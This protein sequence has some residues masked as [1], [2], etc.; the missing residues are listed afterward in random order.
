MSTFV[1]IHG[2]AH[3][4][5]CW[6]KV[7]AALEKHGHTVLAPDLPSHG[8]DKT[9]ISAVTL[10]LYVDSVC[11]LLD[12][13]REP[14]ILVGHSMGGG[15]ITQAAE[16]RPERIK[17]LVYLTAALPRNGQSMFEEFQH[18]TES[19]ALANFVVAPDQS[20]ATF[21]EAGLKEAFY[22]DCS[23]EDITLA[24]LLLTPQ[25]MAPITTPVKTS[26]ARWGRVPRVYIECLRDRALTPPFQKRL[27]TTSPCQQ[28]ISMDT[29]HSPFFSAP[30]E[31]A[32]H[33]MA[34]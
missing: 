33:L 30:E 5:W 2:A 29:S 24:K 10:Q 16:E 21:R 19:A 31:L 25:A 13:Q 12:G 32:R 18:N 20:Y 17:R 26:E 22:E 9:P 1:L 27:Y 34:L 28:V 11:K 14:V 8:R 6:Y 15:I 3:G 4:G 7:V 23:E